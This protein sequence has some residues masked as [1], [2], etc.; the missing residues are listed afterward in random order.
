MYEIVPGA[1]GPR[2]QINASNC[3]HC[4]TCDIMDPYQ[5]ITWVPPEG[6]GG[7]GMKG[8]RTEGLG[9]GDWDS[10]HWSESRWKRAQAAAIPAL[11]V[12]VIAAL[13]ELADLESRRARAPAVRRQRPAPDHG[14]LARRVLTATYFFRRRGIVVMI[15]E[16]F[17]GE[18]IARIIE[19]SAS[20]HRAVRRRAAGSARCSLKREMETG[21]P[22]GIRR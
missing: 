10:A 8:C 20:A 5:V 21:P 4:K 16:N 12:P 6:G 15:S 11:G 9:I 1:D 7:R 19:R 13:G 22:V 18:W 17:D 2:L 14:V 3:V